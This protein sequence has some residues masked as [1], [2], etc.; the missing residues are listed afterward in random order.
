MEAAAQ[1]GRLRNHSPPARKRRQPRRQP[2]AA[3]MRDGERASLRRRHASKRPARSAAAAAGLHASPLARRPAAAAGSGSRRGGDGA[4]GPGGSSWLE[5]LLQEVEDGF[6]VP[7]AVAT[8][9]GHRRGSR[10]ANGNGDG[11]ERVGGGRGGAQ[12]QAAAAAGGGDGRSSRAQ[13]QQ[14]GRRME[15][16]GV[17]ERE[18]GPSGLNGG[19]MEGADDEQPQRIKEKKVLLAGW[20]GGQGWCEYMDEQGGMEGKDQGAGLQQQQEQQ[21]VNDSSTK[22]QLHEY[23]DDLLELDQ[24]GDHQDSHVRACYRMFSREQPLGNPFQLTAFLL[25]NGAVEK[26]IHAWYKMKGPRY[27]A[28]DVSRICWKFQQKLLGKWQSF[29]LKENRL[30]YLPG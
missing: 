19:E 26:K 2:A 23:F 5:A 25:L 24:L 22:Q 14:R 1:V 21:Q 13:R 12:G 3:A 10:R 28:Y 16:G 9:E 11:D 30:V 8:A 4:S 29:S 17:E 7:Q 15:P 27:D 18:G 20:Y 6:S